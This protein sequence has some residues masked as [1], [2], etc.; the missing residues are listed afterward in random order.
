[1]IPQ[2]IRE[3]LNLQDGDQVQ[4]FVQEEMIVIVPPGVLLEEFY[5]LTTNLRST[6]VDVVQELI[7]GHRDEAAGE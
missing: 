4:V 3:A 7:D 2:E 6:R 5:D 1:M